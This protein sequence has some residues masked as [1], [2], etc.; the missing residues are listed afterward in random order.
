MVSECRRRALSYFWKR[1]GIATRRK[2][3]TPLSCNRKFDE[4]M[5]GSENGST[6]RQN[7]KW[8]PL[9]IVI[10]ASESHRRA[11]IYFWK[12]FDIAAGRKMSAPLN[13]NHSFDM[14]LVSWWFFVT[15]PP[16]TRQVLSHNPSTQGGLHKPSDGCLLINY[17]MLFLDFISVKN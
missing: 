15:Q 16:Y 3:S 2:M 7:G 6:Q 10:V 1:L 4:P 13:Y 8:W 11:R 17:S 12:R 5:K 9:S 14:F